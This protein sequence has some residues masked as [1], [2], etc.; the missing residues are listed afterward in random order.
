[1]NALQALRFGMAD[2]RRYRQTRFVLVRH[3]DDFGNW[4]FGHCPA[5]AA[6]TLF[7]VQL[8]HGLAKI[9]GTFGWDAGSDQ[10]TAQMEVAL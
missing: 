7:G 4:T 1:M 10:V 3:R 5:E 6:E 9:V 8:K 2:A